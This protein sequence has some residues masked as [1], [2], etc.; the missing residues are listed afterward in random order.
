MLQFVS[1]LVGLFCFVKSLFFTFTKW[2]SINLLEKETGKIFFF[3]VKRLFFTFTKWNKTYQKR[4]HSDAHQIIASKGTQSK[5]G[6]FTP[7]IYRWN[8]KVTTQC[9]LNNVPSYM[10]S[11]C[12]RRGLCEGSPQFFRGKGSNEQDGKEWRKVSKAGKKRKEVFRSWAKKLMPSIEVKQKEKLSCHTFHPPVL[13][14]LISI[15]QIKANS[16]YGNFICYCIGPA[17]TSVGMYC[18]CQK[19]EIPMEITVVDTKTTE[20][21]NS[22]WGLCQTDNVLFSQYSSTKKYMQVWKYTEV[23]KPTHSQRL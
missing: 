14:R 19:C 23:N 18:V 12:C 16:R 10:S 2:N 1:D 3:F 5:Q 15:I 7:S 4:K 17:W 22:F 13:V 20:I 21:S 9:N 8:Y 6:A 11:L